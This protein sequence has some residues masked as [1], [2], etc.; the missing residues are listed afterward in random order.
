MSSCN[1][2]RYCNPVS[3][4]GGSF[5]TYSFSNTLGDINWYIVWFIY[6]QACQKA[7][8]DVHKSVCTNF[9]LKEIFKL[10]SQLEALQALDS[11]KACACC[12]ASAASSPTSTPAVRHGYGHPD[13]AKIEIVLGQK[14]SSLAWLM[15]NTLRAI[16]Y[17]PAEEH[18]KKALVIFR[19][20]RAAWCKSTLK[21]QDD[22]KDTADLRT[23][24]FLTTTL[25]SS[26]LVNLAQLY[27][28]WNG[29]YMRIHNK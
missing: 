7:N 26:S 20:L 8:Y 1:P 15:G 9:L 11:R 25:L 3:G 18:H 28:Q 17:P 21:I 16:N 23:S 6:N 19:K 2:V 5:Q 13:E 24:D 22:Q 4:K 10:Q 14:H 27:S 29:K 12:Q